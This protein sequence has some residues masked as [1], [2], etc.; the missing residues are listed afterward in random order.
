MTDVLTEVFCDKWFDTEETSSVISAVYYSTDEKSLFVELFSGVTAGYANVSPE[1]YSAMEAL[2]NNRLDGIEDASVGRYWNAWIKPYMTGL[3]T[4]DI[5]IVTQ[6]DRDRINSFKKLMV[7]EVFADEPRLTEEEQAYVDAIANAGDHNETFE[8]DCE[9]CAAEN[10]IAVPA[11]VIQ[12]NSL[13][14]GPIDPQQYMFA[15]AFQSGDNT[16][17]LAVK[18]ASVQDAVDKFQQAIGILGW[19]PVKIV[20]I[21]QHFS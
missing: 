17:S 18:A 5:E 11:D 8:S 21:T 2:N 14:I 10:D 19:V 6:E 3:D 9:A 20:S 13:Y 15:V 4:A 12:A 16:Q 1:I 7:D